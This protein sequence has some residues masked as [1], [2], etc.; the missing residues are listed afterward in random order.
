MLRDVA[1]LA[2][3]ALVL[4][5]VLAAPAPR[6]RYVPPPCDDRWHWKFEPDDCAWR[7]LC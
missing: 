7:A 3:I 1:I 5:A 6:P 4:S 2:A